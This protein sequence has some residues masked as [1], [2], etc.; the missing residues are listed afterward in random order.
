ML[1]LL[2][3]PIGDGHRGVGHLEP[4]AEPPGEDFQQGPGECPKGAV[5]QPDHLGVEGHL[6]GGRRG[7]SGLSGGRGQDE[8]LGR[9]PW[10]QLERLMP[11]GW[12]EAAALLGAA[13]SPSGLR[14]LL[15]VQGKAKQGALCGGVASVGCPIYSC[16]P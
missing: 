14:L 7:R 15:A 3:D 9:R 16:R 6:A 2:A 13:A 11:V 10:T 12:P 1:A 5:K 4:L 8:P